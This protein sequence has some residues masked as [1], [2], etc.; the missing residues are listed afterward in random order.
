MRHALLALAASG[1]L[2]ALPLHAQDHRGS[3]PGGF[4]HG[5]GGFGHNGGFIHGRGFDHGGHGW[6][7]RFYGPRFYGPRFY[8]FYDP[9]PYYGL[10]SPPLYAPPPVEYV[11][12]YYVEPAP[13]VQPEADYSEPQYSYSERSQAQVSPAPAPAPRMER[14]TLSARELFAF[15]EATLKAPQPK[16]DEIAAAMKRDPAI[17]RVR[18]TGYTDRIGSAS[19][20]QKLSERRAEAVKSYLVRQ[21]VEASRLV[22]IGKGKANPVVECND[23]KMEDLVRC[24]EPNRR[25]EVE[26]IT[27]ERVVR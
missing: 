14:V 23:K 18:I 21:G 4:A 19:Y 11:E 5:G 13:P 10:Y 8:G 26:R 12:R 2:L 7:P 25:V 22:A 27:I 3:H 17:E 9:Y 1:A 6:G 16:L 20:N 24:L 15:D